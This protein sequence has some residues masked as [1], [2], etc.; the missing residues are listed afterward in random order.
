MWCNLPNELIA[1][2]LA[3]A[4]SPQSPRL[5]QDI[6]SYYRF[7]TVAGDYYYNLWIVQMYEQTPEDRNWLIN[8]FC[9][10]LNSYQIFMHGV[11]DKFLGTMKKM[12]MLR[13][14]DNETLIQTIYKLLDTR[15]VDYQINA[16]AGLMTHE[17]REQFLS[18]HT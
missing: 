13:N 9:R 3:Y 5:L 17:D 6:Q 16:I 1:I 2:I 4:A 15:D 14:A 10:Y 11:T 18:F 7:K 8:D 12:Y